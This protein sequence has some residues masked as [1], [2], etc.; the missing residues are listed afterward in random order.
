MI[1]LEDDAGVMTLG[2]I[3]V[4]N[5]TGCSHFRKMSASSFR[6]LEVSFLSPMTGLT[7]SEDGI[8]LVNRSATSRI[9]SSFAFVALLIYGG[10]LQV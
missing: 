9:S 7:V 1:T 2:M 10:N 5:T 3:D 6:A 4:G 8:S